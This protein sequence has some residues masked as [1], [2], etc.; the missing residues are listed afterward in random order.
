M[1]NGWTQE[2]RQRQA[3]KI[4][5]WQPWK[6]STGPKTKKGKQTSSRNALKYP[7]NQIMQQE[8]MLIKAMLQEQ[9]NLID[10]FKKSNDHYE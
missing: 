9:R 1:K 5:Q 7:N 6:Q 2:R 8:M 4:K 10:D 3:E